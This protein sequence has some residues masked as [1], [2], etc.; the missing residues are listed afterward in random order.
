M[1]GSRLN[2]NLGHCGF[3]PTGLKQAGMAFDY[4]PEKRRR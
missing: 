3:Q 2:S 4:E 1:S